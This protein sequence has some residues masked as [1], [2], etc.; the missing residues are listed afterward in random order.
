MNIRYY[1]GDIFSLSSQDEF[2]LSLH[3]TT[4]PIRPVPGPVT[5]N[6]SSLNSAEGER[7]GLKEEE[8]YVSAPDTNVSVQSHDS[9]AEGTKDK[10]ALDSLLETRSSSSNGSDADIVNENSRNVETLEGESDDSSVEDDA[11]DKETQD[12]LLL[13]TRS[14]SSN[15]SDDA[16]IVNENNRNV[17]TLESSS[18]SGDNLST[19]VK[20]VMN[21]TKSGVVSIAEMMSLLHQSRATH[22][23]SVCVWFLVSDWTSSALVS[24]A[25]TTTPLYL[26]IF[27]F[28]SENETA[29]CC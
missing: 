12:D 18:R 28:Y 19:E 8:D 2:P 5:V 13:E 27:Y 23:S 25:I 20:R 10:E 22:V 14:S 24:T 1:G 15:G 3:E 16:E 11:K 6:V 29:F 9:F 17:E 26:I 4:E 7:T 21:V